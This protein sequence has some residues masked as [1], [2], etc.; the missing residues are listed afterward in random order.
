[1]ISVQESGNVEASKNMLPMTRYTARPSLAL[2]VAFVPTVQ[3]VHAEPAVSSAFA[4]YTQSGPGCSAGVFRRGSFAYE[5][6]FGLANVENRV[7]ITRDTVFNI[8]SVSKA[9]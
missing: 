9:S 5:G 1:M 3:S 7:H 8:G 6:Y 2:L 4:A